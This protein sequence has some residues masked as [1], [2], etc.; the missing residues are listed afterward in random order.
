MSGA[1]YRNTKLSKLV[2]EKRDSVRILGN[3]ERGDPVWQPYCTGRSGQHAMHTDSGAGHRPPRAHLLRVQHLIRD[4]VP[5]APALTKLLLDSNRAQDGNT[6][7]AATG[8]WGQVD[9][10]QG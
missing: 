5:Q 6:F 2:N 10:V 9:D 8:I 1:A 3:R 7:N 4:H